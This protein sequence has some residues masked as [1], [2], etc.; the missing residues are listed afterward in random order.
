MWWFTCRANWSKNNSQFCNFWTWVNKGWFKIIYCHWNTD[1]T[2]HFTGN[3]RV[4][5]GEQGLTKHRGNVTSLSAIQINEWVLCIFFFV[6]CQFWF[7]DL[8]SST[9]SN[10]PLQAV[11]PLNLPST[12]HSL[13]YLTVC[14]NFVRSRDWHIGSEEVIRIKIL[15]Q[16]CSC[17]ISVEHWV[18]IFNS[19]LQISWS[20][21]V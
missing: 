19:L 15:R 21:V 4:S 7:I 13:T 6:E 12:S 2:K 10:P 14:S 17:S 11:R 9:A 3:H 1:K 20:N 5:K 8:E 18:S 16:P